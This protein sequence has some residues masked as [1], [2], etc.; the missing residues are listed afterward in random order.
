MMIWLNIFQQYNVGFLVFHNY[1]LGLP[2]AAS[3]VCIVPSDF[4]IQMCFLHPI[5][6]AVFAPKLIAAIGVQLPGNQ[7]YLWLLLKVVKFHREASTWI[8]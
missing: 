7:Y 8:Y 4:A 2:M 6:F 5:H 3:S 1:V